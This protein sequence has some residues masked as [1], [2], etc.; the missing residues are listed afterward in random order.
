M[1]E[2]T[3]QHTLKITQPSPPPIEVAM[4]TGTEHKKDL[5]VAIINSA[6][7]QDLLG[8]RVMAECIEPPDLPEEKIIYPGDIAKEKVTNAI[9][10]LPTIAPEKIIL[11]NDVVLYLSAQGND[12]P[13]PL[14]QPGIANKDSMPKYIAKQMQELVTSSQ[15]WQATKTTV[16][17]AKLGVAASRGNKGVLVEITGWLELGKELTRLLASEEGAAEYVQACEQYNA[18]PLAPKQAALYKC[19]G[20]WQLNNLVRFAQEKGYSINAHFDEFAA[21]DNQTAIRWLVQGSAPKAIQAA[22]GWVVNNTKASKHTPDIDWKTI[23]LKPKSK[24]ILEGDMTLTAPVREA[25]IAKPIN[26]ENPIDALAQLHTNEL[27]NLPPVEYARVVTAA[28]RA[29]YYCA[30][31][32]AILQMRASG[33]KYA[34]V[35]NQLGQLRNSN[36]YQR[37]QI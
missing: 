9:R 23:D 21:P 11:A 16:L 24:R 26:I 8:N 7:I 25:R 30:D 31:T 37:G 1:S 18:E 32:M 27:N 6:P 3:L 34:D 17:K 5:F 36:L 19:N 29:L 10:Y 22:I 14:Y 33:N 2:L 15:E 12:N 28:L 13:T 35:R 4:F 20:G